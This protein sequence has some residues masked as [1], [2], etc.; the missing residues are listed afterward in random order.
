MNEYT[1]DTIREGD[2]ALF[3]RVMDEAFFAK[4]GEI[5]G[6]DNPLHTDPLYAKSHGF[7]DR[8]MYGMCTASLYSSLAGVYLPGKNCLLL[9]CDAKFVKPV[10]AGDTLTVTGT[11]QEVD[12]RAKRVVI[13]ADIRNGAGEKVS[14]AK[15]VTGFLEESS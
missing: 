10:Y 11:V 8:V 1:I 15:I 12:L 7:P 13:K 6:D 5:S 4:F 14:R 3:T 9:E 2:T